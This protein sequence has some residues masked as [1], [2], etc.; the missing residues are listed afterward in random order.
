MQRAKQGIVYFIGAGPGDPELITLKGLERLRRADVV[1]HDALVHPAVLRQRRPDAQLINVGKR[2]GCKRIEQE[3]INRMLVD[4]ARRGQVVARLKG[5][6]PL[7]FGRLAEELE[8]VRAAGIAYEVIPG[9][10]AGTALPA[11]LGMPLTDRRR[12]SVLVFVTGHE[13]PDKERSLVPWEKLAALR[14][15]LVVFMGLRTLPRI[16]DK[17]LSGGLSPQTPA[18]VVEWGTTA[19]QRCVRGSVGEI[20]ARV[21]DAALRPPATVFIGEVAGVTNDPG[22]FAE[23]PLFGVTV[24]V[25]RPAEQAGPLIDLLAAHGATPLPMPVIETVA[26]ESWQEVDELV[27]RIS[28]CDWLV[29]TSANGV[30]FFF[31]RLQQLGHD[32]RVLGPVRL[33]VVGQATAAALQQYGVRADLVPASQRSEGLAEELIRVTQPGMTIALVRA[34]RARELLPK[35]LQEAGRKVV[36]AVAY[37]SRDVAEVPGELACEL[38]GLPEFWVTATSPAIARSAHRLLSG[39]FPRPPRPRIRWLSISP[40]T[41]ETLRALGIEPDAEAETPSNEALVQALVRWQTGKMHS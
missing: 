3:A 19:R 24:V 20:A 11:Y 31:R 26:P 30:H 12:A 1:L 10:T 25:T 5:G 6:D 27:A 37:R 2:H 32:A 4:L 41:S 13:S 38:A 28:S 35:A 29:F 14:A 9:V 17:L 39:L 18:V 16:V 7:V 33:A 15:T 36:T 34:D 21:R 23:K 40:L 8:A 22:W